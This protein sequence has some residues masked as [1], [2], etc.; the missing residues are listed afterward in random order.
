MTDNASLMS[1]AFHRV[2][3]DAPDHARAWMSAVQRLDSAC[4]LDK[5]TEH[6]AYLAALP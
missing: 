3:T 5:K 4:A 1:V 2:M 6:L